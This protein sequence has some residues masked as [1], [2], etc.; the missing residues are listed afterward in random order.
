MSEKKDPI[1]VVKHLLAGGI[2][3]AVSRTVVFPLERLKIL[4]Q[5]YLFIFHYKYLSLFQILFYNIG[6]L[7][8]HE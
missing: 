3:G 8:K 4:F 7:I 2:A 5:V 1:V 6:K